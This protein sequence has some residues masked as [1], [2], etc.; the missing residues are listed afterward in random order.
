MR[1]MAVYS[2]NGWFCTRLI[3]VSVIPG[4]NPMALE[5]PEHFSVR[6]TICTDCRATFCDR[7]VDVERGTQGSVLCLVCHGALADGKRMREFSGR[8]VPE[9]IAEHGRGRQSAASGDL[10]AALEA[11]ERAIDLRPG[12]V[13]AH[14]DRGIALRQLGRL[15]EAIDAFGGAIRLEPD[16]MVAYFDRASALEGMGLTQEAIIGYGQAI[17]V[18]PRYLSPHINRALLLNKMG[19]GEEAL[20]DCDRALHLDATGE[21]VDQDGSLRSLAFVARC[22]VLFGL[23]RYPQALEAIDSA[24]E[25]DPDSPHLYNN[26]AAILNRLGR[27]EEAALASLKA[28]EVARGAR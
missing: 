16:Y 1:R 10:T 7:C 17:A 5:D 25:S 8:P 19:R 22:A 27:T 24:I 4:G 26:R 2:C 21:A 14:H 12:Y 15:E 18:H 13:K 23:G 6:F 9:A 28:E 3:S 11:F 20:E